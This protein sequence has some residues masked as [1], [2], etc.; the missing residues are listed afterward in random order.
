M[1]KIGTLILGALLVGCGNEN[2]KNENTVAVSIAPLKYIVEQIADSTVDVVVTVPET[3][4]PETFEIS[5]KQMTKIADA[6]LY[7]AIGLIDFE[8]QLEGK[9]IS[10]APNTKYVKL[11]DGIE[12][13]EGSCGH[14]H[15]AEHNHLVDPH[16]WLSPK[17]MKNMAIKIHMELVANNPKQNEF[18]N[19]NLDKF[20]A[21]IDS[22][23]R[24]IVQKTSQLNSKI[25][26]IVHPSL[27]YFAN[28][29]GLTQVAIEQDGKE[30]SALMI[31]NLIEM[32]KKNG[33]KKILYS[34]QNS[35]A[36]AK[37]I[38]NNTGT[39]VVEYDPLKQNWEEN[40]AYLTDIICN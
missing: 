26:V 13:I 19:A 9:I 3:T 18:Y 28:D 40:M 32:I 4:S 8:Q 22:I 6:N 29:Y 23:D 30:P 37:Q 35:D 16:V 39:N 20:I 2:V 34:R 24:N 14:Q 1:R 38:A 36:V 33:V 5:A 7:F 21:T 25:F 10:V 17:L 11:S 31:T 12:L 15:E 27:S